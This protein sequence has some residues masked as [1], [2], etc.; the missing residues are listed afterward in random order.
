MVFGQRFL[1][2]RQSKGDHKIVTRY[3][4]FQRILNPQLSC[5][6]ELNVVRQSLKCIQCLSLSR[7]NL[8]LIGVHEIS[9]KLIDDRG[10]QNHLIVLHD[11]LKP[12]IS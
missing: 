8:P 1:L 4:F 9:F 6:S 2:R 10:K 3:L 7:E 12:P 5:I 11:P